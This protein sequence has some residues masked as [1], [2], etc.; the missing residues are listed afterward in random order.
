M[1]AVSHETLGT[2]V[3]VGPPAT[4]LPADHPDLAVADQLGL[5]DG[6]VRTDDAAALRAAAVAHPDSSLAWA[7][8]ARAELDA[9]AHGPDAVAAY[10]YARVGYHRGLDALRRARWRGQGLVPVSHPSNRGFLAALLAL[11]EAAARI[12]ED[13]EAERIA[14]FVAQSDP[15]AALALRDGV[16]MGPP[17]ETAG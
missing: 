7:L 14:E 8:L 16:P 2:A 1:T 12:G 6:V 9:G 17:V 4:L 13:E 10:A 3:P 15:T 5:H 11:G